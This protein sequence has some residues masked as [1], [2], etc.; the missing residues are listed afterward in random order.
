[1]S[2]II[3]FS[4]AARPARAVSDQQGPAGVTA[5]NDRALTPGQALRLGKPTLPPSATET[6]KNSRIRIARRVAWWHAG[7]VTDYWRARMDWEYVLEIAQ[8]YEIA[9]SASF[10]TVKDN[11]IRLVDKWREA[12]VKQLLTPA[13][14][15]AAITWKRAK[16]AGRDFSHLP[17]KA[18]RIEQAIADDVAFLAAHPTR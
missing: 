10:P 1:M 11:R 9:D 8:R 17:T 13:P 4:A 6:A 7:R 12:V 5:F 2:N 14:D 15:L 3:Q 18:E 16:L